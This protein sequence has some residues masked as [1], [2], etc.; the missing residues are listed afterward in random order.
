MFD[1]TAGGPERFRQNLIDR[2]KKFLWE[3]EVGDVVA[4]YRKVASVHRKEG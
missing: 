3:N 4:L 1:E 2:H